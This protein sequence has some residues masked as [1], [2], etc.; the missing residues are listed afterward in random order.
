MPD[1]PIPKERGSVRPVTLESEPG[2]SFMCEVRAASWKTGLR[3]GAVVYVNFGTANQVE[4]Q[5]YR[6]QVLPSPDGTN[7]ASGVHVRRLADG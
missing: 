5:W 4:G 7:T 2:K 1:L 6:C 3:P